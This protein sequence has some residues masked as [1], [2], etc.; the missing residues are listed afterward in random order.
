MVKTNRISVMNNYL[1]GIFAR[2]CVEYI[3]SDVNARNCTNT[4]SAGVQ[5]RRGHMILDRYVFLI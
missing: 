5:L 3:H 2:T 1:E 4:R